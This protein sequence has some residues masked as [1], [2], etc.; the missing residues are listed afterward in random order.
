MGERLDRTQEVGGSSPPS[1]IG[2]SR[3]LQEKAAARPPSSIRETFEAQPVTWAA[4]TLAM[5][6]V[7]AAQ[8][9]IPRTEIASVPG[10]LG[11]TVMTALPRGPSRTMRLIPG[12]LR[13]SSVPAGTGVPLWVAVMVMVCGRPLASRLP[14]IETAGQPGAGFEGGVGRDGF[15]GGGVGFGLGLVGG[16]NGRSRPVVADAVAVHGAAG[17]GVQVAV[18]VFVVVRPA[19]PLTATSTSTATDWLAMSVPRL[20]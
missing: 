8:P 16:V 20:Q 10:L 19:D 15:C 13:S 7:V 6:I 14:L 18:A 5:L 3:D 1:S 2:S 17:C 12:P 4:E 11:L 9:R